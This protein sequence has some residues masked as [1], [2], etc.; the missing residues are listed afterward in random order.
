MIVLKYK[1][2]LSKNSHINTKKFLQNAFFVD[3]TQGKMNSACSA[4]K[5]CFHSY[6]FVMTSDTQKKSLSDILETTEKG[7]LFIQQM[8]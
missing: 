4:N 6:K 8:L 5:N 2:K 3:G 1:N 7:R